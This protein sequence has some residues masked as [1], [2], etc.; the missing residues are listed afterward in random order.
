M[1]SYLGPESPRP[2]SV[3]AERY[4]Q[5][6]NFSTGLTVANLERIY[7]ISKC[8]FGGQYEKEICTY[9][10]KHA[11]VNCNDR[12]CLVGEEPEWTSVIQEQLFLIKPVSFIDCKLHQDA[13]KEQLSSNIFDRIIV[14]NCLHLIN[15]PSVD[16]TTKDGSRNFS[17]GIY[18]PLMSCIN[19]LRKS[20]VPHGRLI[21]IHRE[22]NINTLPLPVEV[23]TNWHNSV[24]HS[25]RLIEQLHSER[26]PELE[27]LWEVE[28]IKFNIQK[29]N[30]FNL[31]IHRAFY[32][33]NL[34][35]QKQ[36]ADGLRLLNETYFKYHQGLIEMFDRLLFITIQNKFEP[37]LSTNRLSKFV[38]S[39]KN[40]TY[41]LHITRS[42]RKPDL[43]QTGAHEQLD[44]KMLVTDEVN[45]LL[46]INAQ[47]K[48][49]K[50]NVFK[51]SLPFM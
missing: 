33:L 7:P 12:I 25:S 24:G 44:Y 21:I 42:S 4:F 1:T 50:Q 35:D 26:R 5:R 11:E 39:S 28:T 45:Q 51:T 18:S 29:L 37:L 34:T 16:E 22:P 2:Y 10:A 32:P 38:Q 13:I 17:A 19:M 23:I 9:L 41:S 43:P 49:P 27:Y 8:R 40:P 48:N 30:W 46:N 31:L 15:N 6:I 36:I 14:F 47:R 3:A 20:L